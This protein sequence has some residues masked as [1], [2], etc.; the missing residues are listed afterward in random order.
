MQADK[1][2]VR[3]LAII[4]HRD[5]ELRSGALARFEQL[6][7]RFVQLAADRLAGSVLD[8][9]GRKA[10]DRALIELWPGERSGNWNLERLAP[11][12]GE[13]RL[14]GDPSLLDR[15]VERQRNGLVESDR[16]L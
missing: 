8:Q 14:F 7:E 11:E 1:D 12:A 5:G 10:G 9:L 4:H 3:T 6:V 15:N 2:V 16:A 13:Q